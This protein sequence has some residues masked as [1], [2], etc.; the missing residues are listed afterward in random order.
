MKPVLNKIKAE[1]LINKKQWLIP[2]I[3]KQIIWKQIDFLWP[4]TVHYENIGVFIFLIVTLLLKI[5]KILKPKQLPSIYLN[6]NNLNSNWINH[7]LSKYKVMCYNDRNLNFA[8]LELFLELFFYRIIW[9]RF[10]RETETIDWA[11]VQK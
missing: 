10:H 11:Y 8:S 1:G 9:I 6:Y 5:N 3:L 7:V 2:V 4:K